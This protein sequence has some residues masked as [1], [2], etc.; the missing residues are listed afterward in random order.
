VIHAVVVAAVSVLLIEILLVPFRKIRFTYSAPHFKSNVLLSIS[1]YVL[2]F[3]LITSQVPIA[4]EWAFRDPILYVPLIAALAAIWLA[5]ERYRSEL[6]YIDKR[7]I[8]EEQQEMAVERLDLTF[9][10]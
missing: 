9:S 4:E 6:T 2:G 3:V 10:R 5:V 7:L 8:F 1:F